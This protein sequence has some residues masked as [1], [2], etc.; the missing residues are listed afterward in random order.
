MELDIH[1]S[2]DKHLIN[3][4]SVADPLDPQKENNREYANKEY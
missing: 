4:Q 3:A 1:N 2:I